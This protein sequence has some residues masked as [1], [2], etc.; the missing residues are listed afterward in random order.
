MSA[1]AN[2]S[3]KLDGL[4]WLVAIGLVVAGVVGYNM[5]ADHSALLRVGVVILAVVLAL[6][7]LL[8]TSKG[9]G[10]WKFAK[11]ARTELRKVIWP[12]TNETVRTTIAVM[13]MVI[14]LGLFLWFLDWV[15]V[16]LLG[17]VTVG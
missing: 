2:S 9:Q 15:I 14:I 17:F 10:F 7:T 6:F 16:K 12:T 5:L 13:V 11:E 4:K 8:Q 1:E 3:P